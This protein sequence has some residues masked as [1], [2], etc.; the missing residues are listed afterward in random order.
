MTRQT[1]LDRCRTCVEIED[2]QT[3]D[4]SPKSS[5]LAYWILLS[6]NSPT[7]ILFIYFASGVWA[8]PGQEGLYY[9]AGDSVAWTLTAFPLLV[10]A[11]LTNFTMS[12]SVLVNLFYYKDWC[13]FLLW[14]TIVVVW[15]SVFRY[16]SGRH[17]DG[18]RMTNQESGH[19]FTIPNTP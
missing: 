11:T 19:D 8:P 4:Q 5:K 9:S 7:I 12:R 14:L 15:F 18:S 6:V 2:R 17:F 13:L 1:V 16:D 3:M 10:V